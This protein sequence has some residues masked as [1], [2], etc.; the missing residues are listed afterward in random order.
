MCCDMAF[1]VMPASLL[2]SACD[3]YTVHKATTPST[4]VIVICHELTTQLQT[5]QNDDKQASS[6]VTVLA[7]RKTSDTELH[8]N[9]QVK[10]GSPISTTRLCSTHV[11]E[12]LCNPTK[13]VNM[14]VSSLSVHPSFTAGMVVSATNAIT[15]NARSA[16]RL[17]VTGPIRF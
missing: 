15:G 17:C 13:S 1:G 6:D 2:R 7:W 16:L 11:P 14:A 4:H 8:H 12:C 3:C 5:H 10:I 9:M